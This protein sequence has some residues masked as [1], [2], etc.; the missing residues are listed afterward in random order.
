MDSN[1]DSQECFLGH[2]RA[3]MGRKL[4][5][6]QEAMKSQK[7]L[8]RNFWEETK[9]KLEQMEKFLHETNV[10]QKDHEDK[11]VSQRKEKDKSHK[12]FQSGS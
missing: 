4:R 11:V 1:E 5:R 2:K 12:Y 7:R 8:M 9:E 10:S 3:T 6:V